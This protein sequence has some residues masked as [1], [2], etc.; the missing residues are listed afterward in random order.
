VATVG[1]RDRHHSVRW[2]LLL[3]FFST[4]S[5]VIAASLRARSGS[6]SQPRT[7]AAGLAAV[8]SSA[9]VGGVRR[10]GSTLA[11]GSS[12]SLGS[13]T[14]GGGS[15]LV[16]GGRT[17]R[18]YD[19][20]LRE[21]RKENFNLKLRIYFLEERLGATA[22]SGKRRPPQEG[23]KEDLAHQNASL[24]M[25][26]E[27]LKYD[28]NEKTELLAEASS[29]IEQLETRLA[30]VVREREDERAGLERRLQQMEEEDLTLESRLRQMELDHAEDIG[31]DDDGS[32]LT[33]P[34]PLEASRTSP[35]EDDD[36]GR[37]GSAT[38]GVGARMTTSS[39]SESADE[40]LIREVDAEIARGVSPANRRQ[41]PP[42]ASL[43]LDSPARPSA[44]S[45]VS[46]GQ[47]SSS[48]APSSGGSAAAGP[49]T[50]P[51]GPGSLLSVVQEREEAEAMAARLEEVEN[52]LERSEKALEEVSDICTSVIL[53]CSQ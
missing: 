1:H 20:G 37:R 41:A 45:T 47:S 11:L 31:R 12:G 10:A 50:T 23:S 32:F 40:R 27:S 43:T 22:P 46:S 26:V 33:Q 3:S 28:V 36:E 44:S 7:P 15:A 6:L 49:P 29:A 13:V 53:L 38:I 42:P 16:P 34:L 18:E 2:T 35:P 52:R 48:P 17:V 5:C 19:E 30:E 24:R 51:G 25:Q 9:S 21:L 8:G 39:G 14:P 4:R